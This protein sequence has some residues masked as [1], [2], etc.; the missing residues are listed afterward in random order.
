[1]RTALAAALVLM[2][3]G[4]APAARAADPS[5]T[6]ALLARIV[7][8]YGGW[9]RLERVKG[10]RAE[11][12]VFSVRRHD[13][14]P[15]T[16][17]FL[18]PDR[19]KSLIEYRGGFEARLFDGRQGWRAAEGKAFEP[20]EGPM[21]AALALQVARCAVPW[22]LQER[23]AELRTIAPFVKDTER[24]P[25]LELTLRE[26]M[27]LRVYAD[28]ATGR[29]R[30]SQGVLSVGGQETHFETWYDDWHRVDGVWFAF[31][32]ENWA[33]GQHTGRTTIKSVS[34]DPAVSP[35]EFAPPTPGKAPPAPKG[36]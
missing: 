10:W 12:K 35:K 11:G 28:P 33:S 13:E 29:V 8:A 3:L 14:S 18:R 31:Q 27:Q 30:L 4:A 20:A 16:R 21:L 32:E 25:G 23:A 7:D 2:T 15:T 19:F 26:G 9:T 34:L 5:P 36:D 24:W 1:M 22:I 6:A 17:V